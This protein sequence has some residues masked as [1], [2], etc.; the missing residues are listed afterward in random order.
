MQVTKRHRS[1]QQVKVEDA[2]ED[3]LAAP[4]AAHGFLSNVGGVNQGTQ[5]TSA[6]G[7]AQTHM[8]PEDSS[9]V[10]PKTPKRKRS[11]S[12][13]SKAGSDAV[14][15]T[16]AAA[17]IALGADETAQEVLHISAPQKKQKTKAKAETEAGL[18]GTAA[19]AV[20][21]AVQ[22]VTGDNAASGKSK[23]KKQRVKATEVA[24]DTTTELI[25]APVKGQHP[26]H[27]NGMSVN[28]SSRYLV[29]LGLSR[30]HLCTAIT[31]VTSHLCQRLVLSA[32]SHGSML[33]TWLAILF[34]VSMCLCCNINQCLLLQH[35]T[36][37]HVASLQA[38]VVLQSHQHR[39]KGCSAESDALSSPVHGCAVLHQSCCNTVARTTSLI[40]VPFHVCD[41]PVVLLQASAQIERRS[42][43]KFQRQMLWWKLQ[44][45]VP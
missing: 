27:A 9:P 16:T 19:E 36:H 15:A 10:K 13:K 44:M 37:E 17:D 38:S 39:E 6:A 3:P 45:R 14:S 8:Q 11:A 32:L 23:P 5:Q 2:S 41:L 21:A 35:R 7:N 22:A 24:V 33:N 31:C 20:A 4:V 26:L 43:W 42:R 18:E 25:D 34:H 29:H 28:V 12:T 1:R 30:S 40:H